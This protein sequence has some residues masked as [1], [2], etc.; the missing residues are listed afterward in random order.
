MKK[1]LFKKERHNEK[2]PAGTED[3]LE[4]PRVDDL[5]ASIALR[6]YELYEQEGCCNG[7]DLD[8]WI[9][10]EREILKDKI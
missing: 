4:T 7:H 1:Q 2:V 5:Q 10:A 9:K 3:R 8:N 6:A